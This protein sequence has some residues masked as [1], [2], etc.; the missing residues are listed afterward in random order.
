MQGRPR[1]TTPEEPELIK[2]GQ[3]LV[4]WA[5]EDLS[6]NEKPELRCRFAQWYSLIKGIK[7]KEWDLMVAKPSF[8]GYYEQ[9]QVALSRRFI[10]GSVKDGIAHRFLRIYAPEVKH[11]ENEDLDLK[12]LRE[13]EKE[14]KKMRAELEMKMEMSQQYSEEAKSMFKD[15]MDQVTGLHSSNSAC[16]T[17][18]TESIS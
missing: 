5:T 17:K 10:D 15:L 2:L 1:T 11:S 13:L 12:M 16:I 6:K 8:R 18:S 14:K 4:A 7:H 9:A 3:E